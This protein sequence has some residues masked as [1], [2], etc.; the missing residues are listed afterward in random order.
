MGSLTTGPV[1]SL[2][3]WKA[4]VVR[5]SDKISYIH[6]DMDDAQRAGIISEDNIPITLRLLLG[7]NTKERLNTFVH[8]IV[9][10]SRE[11]N[12]FPCPR[13]LKTGFVTFVL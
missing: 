5:Y 7:E 1:E 10:H 4:R 11:K 8:D 9:E 12:I 13:I 3:P 2:I 6:H